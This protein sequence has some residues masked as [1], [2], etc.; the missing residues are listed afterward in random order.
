MLYQVD[1]TDNIKISIEFNQKLRK[2]YTV[3]WEFCNKQHQKSIN[4]DVEYETKI[5]NNPIELL[6]SINILMNKIER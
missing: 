1:I 5:D 2:S 6:K 3:I 4:T